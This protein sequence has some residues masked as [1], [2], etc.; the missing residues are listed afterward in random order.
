M[1]GHGRIASISSVQVKISVKTIKTIRSSHATGNQI[2]LFL[3][4]QDNSVE[5]FLYLMYTPISTAA[6]TKASKATQLTTGW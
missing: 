3:L 2:Q 1:I 4:N 5:K 6:A